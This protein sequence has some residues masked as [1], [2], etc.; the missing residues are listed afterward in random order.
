MERIQWPPARTPDG[1]QEEIRW[2]F[3]G[4]ST[5]C[6]ED[7]KE[8]I[9]MRDGPQNGETSEEVLHRIIAEIGR[10][11]LSARGKVSADL[12]ASGTMPQ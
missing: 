7:Q 8:G 2:W 9:I 12:Q 4:G 11:S 1:S 6:V 5:V 10:L 3:S